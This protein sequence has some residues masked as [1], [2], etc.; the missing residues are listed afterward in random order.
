MRS[1][2]VVFCVVLT[3]LFLTGAAQTAPRDIMIRS[4]DTVNLIVELHNFGPSDENLSGYRFCTQDDNETLKYSDASGLNG[5]I[6]EAGT[7]VFIHFANDAPPDPDHLNRSTLQGAF[8]SFA[9]PLDNGP[10]ALSL[11]FPLVD[12][13]N[14]NTMA[15]HVQ[16]S[17]NGVDNTIA[18]ERSDEAQA[19]GLWTNQSLW[20]ATAADTTRLDLI[21]GAEITVLHGPNSYD[22]SGP[23]GSGE[24]PEGSLRVTLNGGNLTLNW[25]FSCLASDTGFEVYEGTLGDFT[26]H[27]GIL[28]DVGPLPVATFPAP[29]G[30]AY[31]LIVPT[32]GTSDGGYGFDFAGTPR[33]ESTSP[34]HPQVVLSCD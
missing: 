11:Y 24:V 27:V 4:I 15:D 8:G 19:G 20:V 1:H 13:F 33:P 34:C 3:G 18:D 26:S 14:G 30:N 7:S 6:I 25:G 28:C 17:I 21:P 10:Y 29:V 16:W 9:L 31:Y 12:F 32:D 2:R 5:V 23:A 22:V